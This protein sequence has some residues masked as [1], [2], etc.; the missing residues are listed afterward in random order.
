[1]TK[2]SIFS[3]ERWRIAPY[4]GL[5]E[6][7]IS[8]FS[9]QV[10]DSPESSQ[11][12]RGRHNAVAASASNTI[13]SRVAAPPE[14]TPVTPAPD[15]ILSSS[16]PIVAHSDEIATGVPQQPRKRTYY[17]CADPQATENLE[18]CVAGMSSLQLDYPA[19]V[20]GPS[21]GFQMSYYHSAGIDPRES[22][23]SPDCDD[24]SGAAWDATMVVVARLQV[25]MLA[26]TPV[27]TAA[28]V[29]EAVQQQ[30]AWD[31]EAVRKGI[32]NVLRRHLITTA[33]LPL[34]TDPDYPSSLL[35]RM[36]EDTAYHLQTRLSGP[37]VVSICYYA[38]ASVLAECSLNGD[39]TGQDGTGTGPDPGG[40]GCADAVPGPYASP[41]HQAPLSSC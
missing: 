30:E 37:E 6:E 1:M 27:I 17:N 36:L 23:F 7:P 19:P 13:K 35:A 5:R 11:S 26:T 22:A 2:K 34:P 40:D 28:E 18:D 8:S 10:S 29:D 41:S 3:R 4:S 39:L 20:P 31:E 16:Q 25:G 38:L 32:Q 21:N 9:E 24:I 14:P 15:V 33:P 12:T